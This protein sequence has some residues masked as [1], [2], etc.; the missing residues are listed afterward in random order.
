MKNLKTLFVV[1]PSFLFSLSALGAGVFVDAPAGAL[2]SEDAA[3]IRELVRIA[4]ENQPGFNSVPAAAQA[5]VTLKT[6]VLK[7]G[8]SYIV[9][10]RKT[11]KAGKVLFSDKMKAANIDDMDT[12]SSRLVTSVLQERPVAQTADIT[13]VTEEEETMLKKRIQA[14]NQWIIGIGPGWAT[15]LRSDGGGFTF[16][17]GY[18]WGIDPDYSINLSWTNS[19]G[20]K[21][22]DSTFSDF[23]LGMEYYFTQQKT[24]PFVGAR[25]G[26]ASA[27]PDGNCVISFFGT[28]DTSTASGWAMNGS[29]GLKFFRTSSVNLAVM[30]T[31]YQLFS[32]VGGKNPSLVATEIVVY[33]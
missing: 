6:Q 20:R 27:K 18:L 23:S 3:S 9:T 32:K 11:D 2:P 1:L 33:F 22:D 26:Y 24:S 10:V 8:E 12:V 31:Y 29:A 7:L 17:L 14:T 13:N 21:D 19:S 5:D 28:C 15:N 16:T 30:G 4:V 25:L